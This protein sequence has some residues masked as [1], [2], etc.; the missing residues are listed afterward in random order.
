MN[1]VWSQ[2]MENQRQIKIL[3]LQCVLMIVLNKIGIMINRFYKKKTKSKFKFILLNKINIF[4]LDSS[5]K[6]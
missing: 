4:I 3:F 6:E 2:M 5:I 1:Y